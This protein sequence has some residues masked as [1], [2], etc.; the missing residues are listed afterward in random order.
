M[1][2]RNEIDFGKDIGLVELPAWAKTP[3]QFIIKHREALESEYVSKNLNKW[4]DLIFGYKQYGEESYHALNMF[5]GPNY[6]VRPCYSI[7]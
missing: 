2:Y 5:R 4:I 7:R 6:E 1:V 3:E